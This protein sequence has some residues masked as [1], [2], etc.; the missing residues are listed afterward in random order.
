MDGV[1]GVAGFEV[2]A[3]RWGECI[4]LV[5]APRLSA[6][7]AIRHKQYEVEGEDVYIYF[8]QSGLQNL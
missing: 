5:R 7:E 3:C 8:T 4:A 2:L 6:N 1:F